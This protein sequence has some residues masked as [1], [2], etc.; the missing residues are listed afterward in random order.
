M[1]SQ[2]T[3]LAI[4]HAQYSSE[5]IFFATTEEAEQAILADEKRVSDANLM[6]I[7]L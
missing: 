7:T 3:R 1:R 2:L 5:A 6:Y 4:P